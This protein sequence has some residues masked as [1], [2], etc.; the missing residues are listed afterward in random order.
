VAQDVVVDGVT[1]FP[2]G[3]EGHGRVTTIK[4]PGFMGKPPGEF[5]WTMEY[6]TAVNGDHIPANF[7]PKKRQRAR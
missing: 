4:Q 3:A 7:F 1:V 6:V 5:S 2:H